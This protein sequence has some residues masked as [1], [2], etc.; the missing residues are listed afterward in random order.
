MTSDIRVAIL[1]DHLGIIDGYTHRLS[2]VP[3][4]KIVGYVFYAADL[5]GF[6]QNNPVDVLLMD[7]HVPISEDNHEPM[8]VMH[9]IP[10][11]REN[12]PRMA[13][14]VITMLDQATLVRNLVDIGIQGYILKDDRESIQQ[15]GRV[16]SMVA[17]GGVYFS[18]NAYRLLRKGTG[19]GQSPP[20]TLRQM[21]AL[22]LAAAFPDTSTK[23]LAGRMEISA[24]TFRNLMAAAYQRLGVQ[25]RMAAILKARQLGILTGNQEGKPD[26]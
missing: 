9:V 6:L 12:Y 2:S 1:E 4:I 3:G 20:L 17:T 24:S 14:L 18:Q 13:I 10:A 15:L 23:E 7:L 22:S 19:A 8:P 21:E 5:D 16:V 26:D 25:S 11:L